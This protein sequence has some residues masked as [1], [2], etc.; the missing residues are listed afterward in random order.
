MTHLNPLAAS[1]IP[2]FE[3]SLAPILV[4]QTSLQDSEEVA[5]EEVKA[6]DAETAANAVEESVDGTAETP[7]PVNTVQT[8]EAGTGPRTSVIGEKVR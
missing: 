5:V 8:E 7:A 2:S 4:S 3:S 1:F 6:A